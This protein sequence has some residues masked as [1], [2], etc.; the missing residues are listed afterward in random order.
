[1]LQESFI[2]IF[3]LREIE[4]LKNILLKT[5]F[6]WKRQVTWAVIFQRIFRNRRQV[7]PGLSRI[8][9][10]NNRMQISWLLTSLFAEL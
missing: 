6:P 1:M 10:R 2:V 3:K 4:S 8:E 9:I 7:R 5:W